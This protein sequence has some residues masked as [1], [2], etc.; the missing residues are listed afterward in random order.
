M[1]DV[2]LSE[3]SIGLIEYLED[4]CFSYAS[5]YNMDLYDVY[6]HKIVLEFI[7]AYEMGFDSLRD[8][9]L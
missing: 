9:D 1:Q 2:K 7:L 4:W 8:K 3:A 5:K 6:R